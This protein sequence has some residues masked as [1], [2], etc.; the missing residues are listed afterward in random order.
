MQDIAKELSLRTFSAAQSE[1]NNIWPSLREFIDVQQITD[2]VHDVPII[3]L[4][5]PEDMHVSDD[6]VEQRVAS[7]S[8]ASKFY[9]N[10]E[11]RQVPGSDHM[12][13]LSN[14]QE[15]IQAIL[16]V[17]DSKSVQE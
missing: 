14:S 17:S 5:A 15:I 7:A 2:N 1:I 8:Q 16:D 10:S 11:I 13:I 3:F 9:S 4:I 12:T 6:N